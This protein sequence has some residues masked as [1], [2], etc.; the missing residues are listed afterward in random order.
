MITGDKADMFGQRRP[1]TGAKLLGECRFAEEKATW[2]AVF[3]VGRCY[4]RWS[5]FV[6]AAS[7]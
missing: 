5:L 2:L 6:E 4:V 1:K 3:E 7:P